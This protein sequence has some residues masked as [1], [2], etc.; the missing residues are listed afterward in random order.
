M[1]MPSPATPRL[2]CQTLLVG[3]LH[4]SGSDRDD[5]RRQSGDT[6]N[7]GTDLDATTSF[8][9]IA[10]HPGH[11]AAV[12]VTLELAPLLIDGTPGGFITAAAVAIPAMGGKVE[13][14][15]AGT[16]L[17]IPPVDAAHC[18]P[19]CLRLARATVSPS[20]PAGMVVALTALQAS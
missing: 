19:P 1:A 8:V 15:I 5:Q 20:T 18:R 17:T 11:S 10:S 2:D 6:I 12:T 7:L 4:P 3:S 16:S 13:A 9:L 14:T